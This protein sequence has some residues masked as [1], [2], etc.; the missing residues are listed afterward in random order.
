VR[1]EYDA[2][3]TAIVFDAEGAIFALGDGSVRFEDGA[4]SAAHD[5]AILCAVTHPSGNGVITGGDDGRLI[6][7]R[8][9]DAGVLA[10]SAQGANRGQWIDAVDASAES[11]LIAFS[12][13][14][15]LT[16]LDAKGRRLPPRL[17]A[18]AHRLRRGLRAQGPA[19]RD[20]DLWRRGPLVRPDRRTEA[21]LP[22]MGRVA[23][24][25]DLLPRRGLRG[26]RHAGFP[27]ARLAAEGPEEHA[28]GRLSVQGPGLQL[29]VQRPAAGHLRRP[30]RRALALRRRQRPHGPRSHRDRL[31]RRQPRRPR[32][33]AAEA[34]AAGRRPQRRSRLAGRSS[35]SGSEFPQG[36]QG[37][38]DHGPG[39]ERRRPPRGLGRRR[40]GNAG[41]ADI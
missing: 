19:H 15:T 30:G 37:L 23:H 22:Q 11:G 28:D 27:A 40:D 6:W 29:P 33:L 3:I 35:R 10:T 17:P 14:K 13:G 8:R 36:R 16:V 1:A 31:R 34:R 26:H 21:D 18:R 7:H 4:F 5:G 38:P 12:A 25:R 32:R 24:R 41:V 39:H 9:A 2:Q 20:L